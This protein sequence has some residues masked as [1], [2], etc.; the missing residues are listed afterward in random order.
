[1]ES[2]LYQNKGKVKK[3]EKK[4]TSPLDYLAYF[5]GFWT[6][7]SLENF[8][9]PKT[10]IRTEPKLNWTNLSLYWLNCFH[11]AHIPTQALFSQKKEKTILFSRLCLHCHSS[12]LSLVLR[13]Q[14]WRHV[15]HTTAVTAAFCHSDRLRAG[16][17]LNYWQL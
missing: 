10:K 13:F 3:I 2:F 5:R 4:F 15:P 14:Y 11:C 17:G 12:D 6:N 9:L 16:S 8:F 1:M 7:L